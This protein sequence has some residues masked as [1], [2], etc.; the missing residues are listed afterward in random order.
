LPVLIVATSVVG[1]YAVF[2]GIDIFAQTDFAQVTLAI[3]TSGSFSPP[4]AGAKWPY[5]LG[6]FALLAII[7]IAHQFHQVRR[8][9]GKHRGIQQRNEGFR[10]I[11][12]NHNYSTVPY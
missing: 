9:G 5:M 4:A 12:K 10:S 1:A 2:F 11:P 6:G 8:N 7:G 3:V